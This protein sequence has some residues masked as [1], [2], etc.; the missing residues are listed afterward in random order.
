MSAV[1]VKVKRIP[2]KSLLRK[3]VKLRVWGGERGPPKAAG[4]P[5]V[6]AEETITPD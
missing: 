6:V 5:L 1:S 4:N 3:E 2:I